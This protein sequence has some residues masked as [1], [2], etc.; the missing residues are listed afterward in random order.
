[1]FFITLPFA[2]FFLG[3]NFGEQK[4]RPIELIVIPRT[5]DNDVEEIDTLNW[6]TYRNEEL[7]F[8]FTYPEEWGEATL[9]FYSFNSP[10]KLFLIVFSDTK[11][12]RV[13]GAT[14]NLIWETEYTGIGDFGYH[15]SNGDVLYGHQGG[16]DNYRKTY[17]PIVLEEVLPGQGVL[18][19]INAGD[20][21]G[22]GGF[23]YFSIVNLNSSD[24]VSVALKVLALDQELNEEQINILREFP[25]NVKEF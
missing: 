13:G 4:I 21:P 22:L 25:N 9:S 20:G 23:N 3:M 19:A 1:L 12:W 15:L 6:Q 14:P 5:D 24:Y 11:V 17:Y 16:N 10:G 2:A 18:L 7:G 8:Q